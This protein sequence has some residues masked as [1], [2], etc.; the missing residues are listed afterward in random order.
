VTDV[1]LEM[2]ADQIVE[3]NARLRRVES[4]VEALDAAAAPGVEVAASRTE[5]I[6]PAY[7]SVEAWV[8]E[9]FAPMYGRPLGGEYRWCARWCEHA[10]ALSRL[11]ALWR[12]WETLRLDPAMGMAVWYPRT[13]RSPAVRPALQPRSLQPLLAGPA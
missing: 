10:E 1:D 11:E 3:W 13:P 12:S 2:L 8:T 7:D 4:A 6:K 9:H 5:A